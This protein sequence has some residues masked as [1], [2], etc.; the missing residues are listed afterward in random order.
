MYTFIKRTAPPPYMTIFDMP[1]RDI[2]MVSRE[3]TNTPLQALSLLNDPQF[4]EAAKALAVRMKKEGGEQ[5]NEQLEIGFQMAVSRKPNK[6]ELQILN[7]LYKQEF[8]KFEKSKEN[9]LAYL[10]V[11]DYKVPNEYQ[12]SEMATLTLVANTLLNMDEMYTKR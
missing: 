1:T 3:S 11:G 2:C 8:S 4:V 12:P 5:I 7:D 9:A 10:A 6:K